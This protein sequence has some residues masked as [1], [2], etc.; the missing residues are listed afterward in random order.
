MSFLLKGS[1]TWEEQVGFFF[2]NELGDVNPEERVI[3]VIVTVGRTHKGKRQR[4]DGM[5]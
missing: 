4:K 1:I 3:V 5:E 2:K